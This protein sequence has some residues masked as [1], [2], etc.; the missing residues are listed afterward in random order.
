MKD[1]NTDT[2]KQPSIDTPTAIR[3]LQAGG[4]TVDP[5]T[6]PDADVLALCRTRFSRDGAII[7][8]KTFRNLCL[9]LD[10]DHR[11]R[12]RIRFNELLGQP[13][14]DGEPARDV[15]DLKIATFVERIY[16]SQFE[17]GKIANA[18]RFVS[19]LHSFH[20]VCDYLDG[21]RWDKKPR[22]NRLLASYFGAEGSMLNQVIGRKFAISMVARARKPGAKCDNMLILAGDQGIRKSSGLR[23]LCHDPDWYSDTLLDVKSKDAY[24]MIRG[25]WLYEQA[26]MDSLRRA[27]VSAWKAF[28]SAQFDRYRSSYGRHVEVHPRTGVFCGSCNETEFLTDTTGSRRFWVA[29]CSRVNLEAIEMDRDQIWAEASEAYTNGETWWLDGDGE[30]ELNQSNAVHQV[31]DPWV[32]IIEA[33]LDSQ[34]GP[35]RLE[36][37]M[38]GA[39]HID[40]DKMKHADQWRVGRA[41]RQLGLVKKQAMQD[42]RRTMVWT[43]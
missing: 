14:I 30:K 38:R 20:P 24:Q 9:I 2:P 19:D 18:V 29:R 6:I 27:E 1:N 11:W 10:N 21:L 35:V 42:G 17:P 39:L 37:V 22:L 41:L 15:D 13:V 12:G 32:D 7:P 31:D 43:R 34:V 26:E 28:A 5:A 36:N 4:V 8:T 40:T 16:L 23:A 33:W 25:T 3:L